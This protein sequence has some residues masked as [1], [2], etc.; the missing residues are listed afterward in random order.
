VKDASSPYKEADHARTRHGP[1]RRPVGDAALYEALLRLQLGG[2]VST[3]LDPE[4]RCGE[5]HD[6]GPGGGR[7]QV[8]PLLKHVR[9]EVGRQEDT[10]R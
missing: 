5:F 7:G 4:K 2:P 3:S 9:P 8:G 6:A 10:Q 1:P